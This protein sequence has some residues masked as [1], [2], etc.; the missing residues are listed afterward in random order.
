VVEKGGGG[1]NYVR[2][3]CIRVVCWKSKATCVHAHAHAHALAQPRTHTDGYVQGVSYMTG[4]NCDLFTHNQ[5]RSYLNHLVILT[6]F[7][8]QQWFRKRASILCYMYIASLVYTCFSVPSTYNFSWVTSLLPVIMVIQLNLYSHKHEV[9]TSEYYRS[10]QNHWSIHL[11]ENKTLF[12]RLTYCL[13][14]INRK[15][16]NECKLNDNVSKDCTEI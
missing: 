5:S 2:I 14:Y 15:L 8:R 3:W 9:T 7:P 1:T 16:D 12:L 11:Q 10:I 4:T 13:H 6:A